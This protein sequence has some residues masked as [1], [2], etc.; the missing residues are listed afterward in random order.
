MNTLIV[1]VKYEVWFFLS[2][3][4]LI[5]CYQILTGKI[6]IKGLFCEKNGSKRTSSVRI[7]L[8]FMTVLSAGYYLFRVLENPTEFPKDIQAVLMFMGGS[9]MVYLGSKSYSLILQKK[10]NTLSR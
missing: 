1:F 5:V 2:M 8:V 4:M 6:N 9:N 3:L 7:Q 10:K